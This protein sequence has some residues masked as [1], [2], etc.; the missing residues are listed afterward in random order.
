[1]DNTT[2]TSLITK[3]TGIAIV[4]PTGITG[5]RYDDDQMVVSVGP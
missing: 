2:P 4:D 5:T 1:M 3:P